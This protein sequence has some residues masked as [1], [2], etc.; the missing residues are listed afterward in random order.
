MLAENPWFSVTFDPLA[1]VVRFRRTGLAV[2]DVDALGQLYAQVR[3]TFPVEARGSMGL[4]V[5]MRDA[6]L[7][8]DPRFQKI[9]VAEIPALSA[10]W[11]RAAT[12]VQTEPGAHTVASLQKRAGVD[13]R[14]F[15]DE[16]A[17]LSWLLGVDD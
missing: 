6:P 8:T 11:R 4:L 1:R 2:D 10:G 12:L 3:A 7:R 5:D 9:I 14:V 16:D 15:V 17:A 13:S